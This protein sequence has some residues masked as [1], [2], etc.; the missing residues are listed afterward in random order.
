RRA[1]RRPP[2]ELP[3]VLLAGLA[4]IGFGIVLGP[5]ARLLALG[6]GLAVLMVWLMRRDTPPRNSC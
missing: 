3:G 4:G 5:E 2:V 6:P 1:N